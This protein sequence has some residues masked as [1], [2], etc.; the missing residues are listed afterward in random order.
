MSVKCILFVD[1]EPQILQSIKRLFANQGYEVL[2]CVSPSEALELLKNKPVKVIVSDYRMPA[3]NGAEFLK[4]AR[5]I[6]P[7]A[8]RLVLSGYTD[9]QGVTELIE[10]GEIYK[11]LMKPWDNDEIKTAIREAFAYQARLATF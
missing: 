3:M 2:T 6:R 1:D 7:E 8:V 9:A 4:K 10:K 11:F 5:V